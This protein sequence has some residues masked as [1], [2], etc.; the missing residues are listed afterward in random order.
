MARTHK[1]D[2]LKVKQRK[3]R[4]RRFWSGGN[5]AY[6][7]ADSWAKQTH[8]HSD[9]GVESDFRTA[10]RAAVRDDLH[11]L[12]GPSDAAAELSETDGFLDPPRDSRHGA[13]AW[14]D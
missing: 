12:I 13:A 7:D 9:R 5:F 11:S 6:R 4:L 2:P 14:Y 10:E 3:M 8:D 1:T